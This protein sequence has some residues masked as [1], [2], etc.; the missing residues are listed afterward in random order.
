M[1]KLVGKKVRLL[2]PKELVKRGFEI[3][4]SSD[5]EFV[6]IREKGK[7]DSEAVGINSDLFSHDAVLV[8]HRTLDVYAYALCEKAFAIIEDK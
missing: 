8:N 2:S 5:G 1:E 6:W 4:I 3:D 7:E